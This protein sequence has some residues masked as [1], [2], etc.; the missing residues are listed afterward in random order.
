MYATSLVLMGTL[1]VTSEIFLFTA[2]GLQELGKPST[3]CE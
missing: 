3:H 1:F 2:A